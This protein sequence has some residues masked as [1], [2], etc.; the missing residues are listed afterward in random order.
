VGRTAHRAYEGEGR[1]LKIGGRLSR[2]ADASPGRTERLIALARQAWGSEM[3]IY[4]DANGSYDARYAS[5]SKMLK[6]HNVCSSRSRAR[7]KTWTKPSGRRRSGH[8]CRRRRKDA[9]LP[10]FE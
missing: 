7:S 6:E 8:A 4:V 5:K 10:R 3:N 9:S 2:N 1:E